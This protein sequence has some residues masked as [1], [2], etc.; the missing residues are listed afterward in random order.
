[1]TG[2]VGDAIHRAQ[3]AVE[4]LASDAARVSALW[5]LAGL[6]LHL[7]SQAVR[8]RGWWHILRA[9]YPEAHD[10]RARD[11]VRA[12]FA[13]A[14]LNAVLPARGGD[15]VKVAFL[16]RRIE[17]SSYP[18]LFATFLPETLF[19]TVC[20]AVLVVWMLAH[21][22]LP[23]PRVP[24]EL[25]SPDVSLYL[26]HP[27]LAS[28]CTL[29]LAAAAALLLRAIRRRSASV[30]ARLRQGLAIVASPKR[31]VVEVASWQALGRLV[32]LG[33]LWCF[34]AAF[35]L[36]ATPETAVL[37]MAAQGG[38]RIIPL[39]PVS[40]GLRLAMLSYGLVELTRHPVDP[41]AV[42]VFTFGVGA[43]Q[44]VLMLT[45]SLVL[46]GRELPHAAGVRAAIRT[47]KQAG[48]AQPVGDDRRGRARARR[49]LHGL[50]AP[51]VPAVEAFDRLAADV[52][53]GDEPVA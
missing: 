29:G 52:T 28:A 3:E 31:F 4:L 20:G 25:P 24:G 18:T 22:F 43:A 46:I 38:G 2:V 7:L 30:I 49:A 47:A 35:Q 27:V 23:I 11:V 44:F 40:T 19:E 41:A 37:V 39:A 14:G 36:P 13:G 33:S 5:L 21:G 8:N 9:S 42:T 51:A 45:I 34:L 15:A 6:A 50:R 10:L 12:Y 17:G 48:R 32:R 26:Q 16:R 53:G 1:M